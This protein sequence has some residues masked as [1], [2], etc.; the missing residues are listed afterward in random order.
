MFISLAIWPC[1][2]AE[3]NTFIYKTLLDSVIT[4]SVDKLLVLYLIE[5]IK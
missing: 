3:K 2:A 5:V 4:L 1:A